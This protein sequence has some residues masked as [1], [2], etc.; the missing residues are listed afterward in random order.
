MMGAIKLEDALLI[1][2]CVCLG[3]LAG[4][5]IAHAWVSRNMGIRK[6]MG[7]AKLSQRVVDR[8]RQ[9]GDKCDVPAEAAK[10][11]LH[12]K[13]IQR[14]LNYETWMPPPTDDEHKECAW[15]HALFE[16]RYPSGRWRSDKQWASKRTCN[17]SCNMYLLWQEGP[18][19]KNRGC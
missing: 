17:P 12:P 2:I 14:I 10:Y 8:L 18:Y 3:S 9:L 4:V 13:T 6:P 5:T 19:R 16:R 15:C 7:G 11:Q 1:L